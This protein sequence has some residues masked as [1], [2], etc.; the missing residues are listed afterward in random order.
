MAWKLLSSS[1]LLLLARPLW[2]CI[3][4]IYIYILLPKLGE[5]LHIINKYI[6]IFYLGLPTLAVPYN[7]IFPILLAFDFTELYASVLA[8]S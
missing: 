2:F 8:G 6:A 1:E 7:K 4:V 5:L 3:A